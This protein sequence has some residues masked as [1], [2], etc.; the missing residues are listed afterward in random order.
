MNNLNNMPKYIINKMFLF[1]SHPLADIYRDACICSSCKGFNKDQIRKMCHHC[2]KY[3]CKSCK[4]YEQFARKLDD[5][6][7]FC[8]EDCFEDRIGEIAGDAKR[9]KIRIRRTLKEYIKDKF[10]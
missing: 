6:R 9:W 4:D 10:G 8:C 3:I 7:L 5:Q 1:M 2:N